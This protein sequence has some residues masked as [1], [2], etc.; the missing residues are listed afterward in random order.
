M[1]A[2]IISKSN[3]RYYYNIRFVDL[4]RP[5]AG[6]Y[7]KP[8]EFWSRSQPVRRSPQEDVGDDG[9]PGD[10]V[11]ALAE[12]AEGPLPVEHEREGREQPSLRQISPVMSQFGSSSFRSDRVHR[13]PE[14]QSEMHLSP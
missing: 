3:F 5:D 2:K 1:R 13:L 8:G 11:E 9:D 12:E 6:I 14:N 7:L 10:N 4:D